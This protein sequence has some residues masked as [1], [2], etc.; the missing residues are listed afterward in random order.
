MDKSFISLKKNCNQRT[1]KELIPSVKDQVY[2]IQDF[3]SPNFLDRLFSFHRPSDN[4]NIEPCL[5]TRPLLSFIE[6]VTQKIDD[7]KLFLDDLREAYITRAVAFCS[8]ENKEYELDNLKREMRRSHLKIV[9]YGYNSSI[10]EEFVRSFDSYR[11]LNEKNQLFKAKEPMDDFKRCFDKKIESIVQAC[12]EDQLPTPY[13][14]TIEEAKDSRVQRFSEIQDKIVQMHQRKV[15]D[16]NVKLLKQNRQNYLTFI[17]TT[18]PRFPQ[19]LWK[20]QLEVLDLKS[21]TFGHPLR[22]PDRQPKDALPFELIDSLHL[23]V[24]PTFTSRRLDIYKLSSKK[25]Q[26]VWRLSLQSIFTNAMPGT[27]FAFDIINPQNLLVIG[28]GQELK[29]V[30]IFTKKVVYERRTTVSNI[31]AISHMKSLNLLAVLEHT[32]PMRIY[33][34][35]S[36]KNSLRLEHTREIKFVNN[37]VRRIVPHS[38][39]NSF[40]ISE[41]S[42]TM[43]LHRVQLQF[44]QIKQ[45][46]FDTQIAP[47]DRNCVSIA[48][49]SDHFLLSYGMISSTLDAI[50]CTGIRT[51]GVSGE[52]FAD[53]DV[54][55][56]DPMIALFDSAEIR[57]GY[58]TLENFIFIMSKGHDGESSYPER[59]FRQVCK[60]FIKR[61]VRNADMKEATT[62]SY[63]Y[64][65]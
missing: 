15:F 51:L 61:I 36:A 24:I 39:S 49:S 31:A 3:I 50:S 48:E 19:Q 40:I 9:Q 43:V 52:K 5:S 2:S 21:G 16:T 54:F 58:S 62:V 64:I 46:R 7:T 12:K 33:S 34:I 13:M 65:F 11:T 63:S 26:L 4:F 18:P 37:S 41:I 42:H 32:G 28:Y 30:N 1:S 6:A 14:V 45:D 23:V 22:L 17:S 29:L 10:A 38:H 53:V 20:S 56:S 55:K 25:M 47:R 8:E 44:N 57:V 35:M 60:L 59:Y 27:R